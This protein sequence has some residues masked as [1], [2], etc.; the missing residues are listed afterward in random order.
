[1]KQAAGKD[2]DSSEKKAEVET[3]FIQSREA[4]I[5]IK[6]GMDGLAMPIH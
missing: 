2:E 6:K 1:M 5:Q 4:A 3:N